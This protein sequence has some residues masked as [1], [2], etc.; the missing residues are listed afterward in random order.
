[1]L[2]EPLYHKPAD[3]WSCAVILGELFLSVERKQLLFS[4][5]HC[6][7]LSPSKKTT[8]YMHGLPETEGHIMEMIFDLLGTPSEADQSFVTDSLARAYLKKFKTRARCD[9]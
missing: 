6:F 4:G 9:F 1:M 8:S 7:P 2:L 5:Q 3:I